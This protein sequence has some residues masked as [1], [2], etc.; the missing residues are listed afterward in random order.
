MTG[1]WLGCI[2]GISLPACLP[3]VLVEDVVV[4]GCPDTD[5]E[6]TVVP[7][8]VELAEEVAEE[9]EEEEEE[10]VA[11]GVILPRLGMTSAEV[12]ATAAVSVAVAAL[13]AAVSVAEAV[14]LA[15]VSSDSSRS[16]GG[17]LRSSCSI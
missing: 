15:A 14:V 13:T 2:G 6:V 16:R 9:E 12:A 5:V 10:E 17:S 7:P 11:E 8:P 3:L 1:F 4:V